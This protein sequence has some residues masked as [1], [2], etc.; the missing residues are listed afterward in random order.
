MIIIYFLLVLLISIEVAA[1]IVYGRFV[2][3]QTTD[4]YM[5]LDES[6]LELRSKLK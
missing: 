6:K 2:S 4:T 1:F 5:N 3:K